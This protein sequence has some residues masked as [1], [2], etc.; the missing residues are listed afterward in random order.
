[1]GLRLMCNVRHD[2]DKTSVATVPC[3]GPPPDVQ[4]QACMQRSHA[5]PMPCWVRGARGISQ[6]APYPIAKVAML[7]KTTYQVNGTLV[8][9][10]RYKFNAKP[11][12]MP[13]IAPRSE[14]LLVI[15]PSRKTPSSE[16]YATEAI[17][18]PIS[19]TLPPC[20]ARI[21][22]PNR[23]NPQ[24]MVTMRERRTRRSSDE[25]GTNRA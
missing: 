4:C 11:H 2:K 12:D 25:E 21:A 22:K 15:M 5:V 3:H 20:R 6:L 18:N 13:T 7:P 19:S 8:N 16:P 9:R 24:T 10:H 23:S 14:A 1:M 17:D